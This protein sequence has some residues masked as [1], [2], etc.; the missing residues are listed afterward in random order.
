MEKLSP[1]TDRNRV[2][3]LLRVLPE[4]FLQICVL[5]PTQLVCFCARVGRLCGAESTPLAEHPCDTCTD[6]DQGDQ[7]QNA[8]RLELHAP[9]M[10]L[11]RQSSGA[12]SGSA[13]SCVV[14]G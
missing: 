6:N 3:L 2:V 12:A 11:T 8:K 14:K 9:R 4:I 10:D 13:A 7:S 1:N 5:D